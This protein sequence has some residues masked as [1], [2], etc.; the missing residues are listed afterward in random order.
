MNRDKVNKNAAKVREKVIKSKRFYCEVCSS[1]SK[2][3]D[4]LTVHLKT[5]AHGDREAG[6]PVPETSS[7][8]IR[9]KAARDA[10]IAAG[11][12]R[13][14]VCNNNFGLVG[15]LERHLNQAGHKKKA[16]KAEADL[17]AST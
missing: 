15:S 9:I 6:I 8:A 5:Q 3:Q 11:K 17:A 10:A 12:F 16:A 1:A 2:S 4:A 14:A 13:C 7:N